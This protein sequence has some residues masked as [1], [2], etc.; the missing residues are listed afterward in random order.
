MK[1]NKSRV[2]LTSGE[3][4]F[5]LLVWMVIV[6]VITVGFIWDDG[7]S[8]KNGPVPVVTPTPTHVV[9]DEPTPTP[10]PNYQEIVG[11]DTPVTMFVVGDHVIE[12]SAPSQSSTPKTG[13]SHM[14]GEAVTVIA[15]ARSEKFLDWYQLQSGGWIR[16]DLL[17]ATY[18]GG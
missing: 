7:G 11:F 17:A 9:E 16:E 6:V 8:G 1:R 18:N 2:T 3:G 5:L 14:N 13:R 10:D 4:Q 12:R 15:V